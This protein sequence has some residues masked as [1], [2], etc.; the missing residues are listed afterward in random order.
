L[1][2]EVAVAVRKI[3][4]SLHKSHLFAQQIDLFKSFK[5]FRYRCHIA[6]S[7]GSRLD[8]I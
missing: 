8:D 1:K 4:P 3:V 5:A 7:R 6:G 2:A